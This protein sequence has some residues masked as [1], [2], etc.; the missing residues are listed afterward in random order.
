M[1]TTTR[2]IQR[3]IVVFMGLG[4]LLTILPELV[5]GQPYISTKGGLIN[6]IEGRVEVHSARDMRWEKARP[7]LQLRQ[8][9]ELR[10][11]E[12]S[13][14]EML[15]NPG[16]F[17]RLGPESAARLVND[18]LT[19]LSLEVVSG[20]LEIEAGNVKSIGHIDVSVFGH[21][22]SIM[23]D[24]IYRFDV[25]DPGPATARV[26]RGEMVTVSANGKTT[27]IKKSSQAT[28]AGANA[29]LAVGRFDTKQ[30]DSLSE[31]SAFRAGQL[32]QSN[33]GVIRSFSQGYYPGGY[34][35]YYGAGIY[36]LG[37]GWFYDPF[38]S[39]YTFMPCRNDFFSPYGG[40]LFSPIVVVSNGGHH[41]IGTSRSEGTARGHESI[42]SSSGGGFTPSSS[43]SV[44]PSAVGSPSGGTS[45]SEGGARSP[46]PIRH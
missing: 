4:A 7:L 41:G 6:V 38:F 35:G 10:V 16:S 42:G 45:R 33:R 20:S 36:G 11:H 34:Y 46:T 1:K 3:W 13:R 5:L 8:G 25:S 29:T 40:Y 26:F 43:S 14:A 21:L 24:G 9:D 22:F 31:W 19:E 2:G 44:G 27:R 32:A 37:C 12:N 30:M 17:A 39:F 28:I 18:R 23:K 15:L